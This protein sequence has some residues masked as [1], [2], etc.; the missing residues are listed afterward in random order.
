MTTITETGDCSND[1]YATDEHWTCGFEE[2]EHQ[3][4]VYARI[5][6]FL[7]A[8][9]DELFASH[10]FVVTFELVPH[11]PAD[12]A[13]LLKGETWIDEMAANGHDR[14][15][16]KREAIQGLGGGVPANHVFHGLVGNDVDVEV[17]D[18]TGHPRFARREDAVAYARAAI[19]SKADGVMC[20]V[21][22][23]LDRAYNMLGD[24]GWDLLRPSALGRA[25]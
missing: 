1:I 25:A 2:S 15:E 4:G 5:E 11:D 19:E 7:E 18:Y 24:T 9:G 14:A 16:L 22:F 12:T 3:L 10:P 6:N 13:P 20:L 23:V 21:G 8:T 17:D